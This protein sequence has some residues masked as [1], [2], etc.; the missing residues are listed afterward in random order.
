MQENVATV[1]RLML[2][3]MLLLMQTKVVFKAE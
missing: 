2:L 1:I 3:L